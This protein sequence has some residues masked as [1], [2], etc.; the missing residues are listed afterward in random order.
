M[1]KAKILNETWKICP[2]IYIFSMREHA[3]LGV[4]VIA[5]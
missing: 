5:R 4:Y 3:Q 2:A 1:G